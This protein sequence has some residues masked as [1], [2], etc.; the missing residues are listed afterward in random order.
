[1]GRFDDDFRNLSS[2]Y[3]IINEESEAEEDTIPAMTRE[4]YDKYRKI[5]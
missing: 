2:I 1:M 4:E 3:T 5:S